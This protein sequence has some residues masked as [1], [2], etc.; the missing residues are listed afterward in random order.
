MKARILAV[1]S[2]VFL[3]YG[4][5]PLTAQQPPVGG[6]MMPQAG[7]TEEGVPDHEGMMYGGMMGRQMMGDRGM[8]ARGMMGGIGH[9]GMM[10]GMGRRGMMHPLAMRMIF[11]LVDADGD[12]KISLQEWQAAHERLFKAMDT[13][14]DATV[15][16]E[17]M[18]A[19]MHGSN[20]STPHQ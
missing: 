6:A 18:E 12:G 8:M 7:Q 5:I 17:E 13:D 4:A 3:T 19:F 11:A 15:T 9:R 16:L 20:K 10:G 2:A 14:H 1:T